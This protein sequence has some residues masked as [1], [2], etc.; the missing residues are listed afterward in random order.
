MISI[1]LEN[2][3][4]SSAMRTES[5]S[6]SS[7]S[8]TSC[9]QARARR[10]CS[11]S[12]DMHTNNLAQ[13]EQLNFFLGLVFSFPPQFLLVLHPFSSYSISNSYSFFSRLFPASVVPPSFLFSP[14]FV[15]FFGG[16][17]CVGHSFA[18]VA[19]FVSG[20]EPRAPPHKAGAL[21]C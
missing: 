3:G 18:Y 13:Y 19:H 5:T 11:C 2:G 14:F 8:T 1:R 20:F 4:A 15:Y 16:L 9:T 12:C 21:P 7:T 6:R 17:E 10:M